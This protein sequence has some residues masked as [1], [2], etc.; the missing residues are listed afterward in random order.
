MKR[1]LTCFLTLVLVFSFS[2]NV[3][4]AVNVG[5]T[6]VTGTVPSGFTA[7]E[8]IVGAGAVVTLPATLN[9]MYNE[10]YDTFYS[11]DVITT[12]GSINEASEVVIDTPKSVTYTGLNTSSTVEGFVKF[13]T[14]CRRTWNSSQVTASDTEDILIQVPPT[15][16]TEPDDYSATVNFVI[17]SAPVGMYNPVTIPTTYLDFNESI[18]YTVANNGK[19]DFYAF[20]NSDSLNMTAINLNGLNS[21]A[22]PFGM[23]KYFNGTS[24]P[25]NINN[26][27]IKYIELPESSKFIGASHYFVNVAYAAAQSNYRVEHMYSNYLRTWIMGLKDL[28]VIVVPECIT[29]DQLHKSFDMS[30]GNLNYSF[31][32]KTVVD[33]GEIV[34]DGTFFVKD[35]DGT[36]WIYVPNIVYRGTMEEWKALSLYDDWQF[37]NAANLVTVHCTDG[38]LYY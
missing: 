25:G 34:G 28:Q 27:V 37:N 18:G 30:N 22:N 36:K 16:V 17:K 26:N 5:N 35:I 8:S 9:L 21:S 32:D 29:S 33:T 15:D 7:D 11:K 24:T 3:N 2:F 14:D 12:Y 38:K 19:V 1:I 13:G 23:V 10:S 20:F 6:P 4:A 31:H